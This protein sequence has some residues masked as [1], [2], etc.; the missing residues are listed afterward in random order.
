[1]IEKKECSIS[2]FYALKK[3]EPSANVTEGENT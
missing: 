2:N 1:M 3:V